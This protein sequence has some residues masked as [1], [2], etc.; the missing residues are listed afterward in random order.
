MTTSGQIGDVGPA[1]VG[2]ELLAILDEERLPPERS[3][4]HELLAIL[5]RGKWIVLAVVTGLVT[6]GA[7]SE[8]PLYEAESSLL[9]RIGREYIY[10][11]EDGRT[12]TARTPSLSEM[13]N[14][15]VEILSSRD[16]AEQ[17]VREI[18]ADRLYPEL[19]EIAPDAQVLTD[20]AVLRFRKAASIRPVLESSVIKVG[21]EHEVPQ[22]AAD[23]V[24]LLVERFKD[25]Q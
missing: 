22:L 20:T 9:V 6:W 24:N 19:V 25:K 17:V 4:A 14:S 23:A 16:L 11:P 12:E 7:L 18:G 5:P 21:F 3:A 13:V 8:Q 1:D 15:E 10:R 2:D